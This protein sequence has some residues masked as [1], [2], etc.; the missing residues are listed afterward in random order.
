ME[1][2]LTIKDIEILK[3]S[4]RY[5][6]SRVENSSDHNYET[7]PIKGDK[8]NELQALKAKLSEIAK[9]IQR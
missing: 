1:N 5:S 2:P 7:Y 3:E 4:L 6:I 8:I 9:E